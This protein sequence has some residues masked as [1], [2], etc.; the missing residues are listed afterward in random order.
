[1]E[2]TNTKQWK[3]EL[4]VD[5]NNHWRSLNLDCKDRLSEVSVV[6]MCIQGIHWS[7]LYIFQGIRP[8][9]F[10]EL[11]TEA[12]DMELSITNHG[13][14]KDVIIDQWK[15]RNDGKNGDK[16]S[17]KPIQESMTM[18]V[19]EFGPYCV[20]EIFNANNINLRAQR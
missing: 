8:R 19:K 4:V 5:Y 2:L 16:T 20:N 18:E 3:E 14:K 10:E 6:E 9:T 17:K 11:A 12:H 7:L 1:M 13:V 15:E